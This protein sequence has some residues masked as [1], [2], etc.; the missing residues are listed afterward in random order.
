MHTEQLM[1][2]M[3]ITQCKQQDQG[4][5]WPSLEHKSSSLVQGVGG[6]L[7]VGQAQRA[8]RA[9][10][11]SPLPP[12]QVDTVLTHPAHLELQTGASSEEASPV[13]D[14]THRL[15]LVA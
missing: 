6:E 3:P 2:T 7:G 10:A 12:L 15:C 9:P 4:F 13:L 5:V 11:P 1:V 8:L 14:P